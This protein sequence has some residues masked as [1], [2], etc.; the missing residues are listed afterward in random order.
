VYQEKYIY[1]RGD[2]KNHES[3]ILNIPNLKIYDFSM[4]GY[5]AHAPRMNESRNQRFFYEKLVGSDLLKARKTKN[6]VALGWDVGWEVVG[7]ESGSFTSSSINTDYAS[8]N[9]ASYLLVR[10]LLLSTFSLDL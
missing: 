4:L 10:P 6:R 5:H 9:L 2:K 7:N 1:L 3:G 8:D